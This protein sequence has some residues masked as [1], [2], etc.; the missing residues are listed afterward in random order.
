MDNCTEVW[1]EILNKF[2]EL[3]VKENISSNNIIIEM[4][5]LV[6]KLFKDNDSVD[7]GQH[8]SHSS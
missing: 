7:S 2:I 8:N 3:Y 1:E 5:V 6:D 4:L